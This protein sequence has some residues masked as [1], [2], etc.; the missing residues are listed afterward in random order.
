MME[1]TLIWKNEWNISPQTI[2]TKNTNY[3]NQF[4]NLTETRFCQFQPLFSSTVLCTALCQPEQNGV[5][6]F[7]PTYFKNTFCIFRWNLSLPSLYYFFF[8][9][10]SQLDH[11]WIM[12]TLKWLSMSFIH[13]CRNT[14]KTRHNWSYMDSTKLNILLCCKKCVD[15]Q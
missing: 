12:D 3:V 4:Y 8:H 7:L 2:K 6:S 9:F 5:K 13:Q 1:L 15:V 14:W 10:D 11:Q